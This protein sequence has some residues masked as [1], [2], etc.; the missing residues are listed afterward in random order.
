VK[1]RNLKQLLC[2]F[3][4]L[5]GLKINFYK[6]YFFCFGGTEEL[7]EHYS[8]IFGCQGGSYPFRYLGIYMHFRKLS[9]NDW[10]ML[11][12]ELRK[13]LSS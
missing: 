5:L 9:N 3:E 1:E 10:K 11:G 8:N 13:K 7:R 6:S 2:A 12:Q 4:Q